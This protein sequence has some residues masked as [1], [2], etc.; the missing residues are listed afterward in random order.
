ML[1]TFT[2]NNGVNSVFTHNALAKSVFSS[3]S[4]PLYP[5]LMRAYCY[6]RRNPI[7]T[8]YIVEK[9]SELAKALILVNYDKEWSRSW[10]RVGFARRLRSA[11]LRRLSE[12][13]LWAWMFLK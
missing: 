7:Q 9:L 3:T 4:S 2:W 10:L 12:R 6:C 5:D 8:D 13:N 1:E 11:L